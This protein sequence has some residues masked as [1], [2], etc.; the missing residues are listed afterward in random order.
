V[1]D[2]VVTLVLPRE[3]DFHPVAR[4]VLAGLGARLQLTYESLE[5]LEL[6][7]GAL[8]EQDDGEVDLTVRVTVGQDTI[9]TEVG[10]FERGLRAEL[11]R[12]DQG[13]IGLRRLLETMVDTVELEED[14]TGT[15]VRL[16]KHVDL[17]QTRS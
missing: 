16:V 15:V 10:P 12:D 4:L 9:Q 6:A 17:A 13:G 1:G 7:L 5:D 2:D 8:L 3:R 14:P 11:A